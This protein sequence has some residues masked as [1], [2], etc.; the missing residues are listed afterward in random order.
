M[1]TKSSSPNKLTT[2]LYFLAFIGLGA[3]TS[4]LGPS[5]PSLAAH[6]QTNLAEIGFLFMARSLGYMIGS[7]RGGHAFDKLP[8]HNLLAGLLLL[9]SASLAL[10]PVISQLWVL[11][12]VL[13]FLGIGEGALD[14]GTNLLLSWVHRENATPFLNALHFFFGA[15]SFLGPIIVAQALRLE[16]DIQWAYWILAIYP[17]FLLIGMLRQPSPASPQTI[18]QK[19]NG[20]VPAFQTFLIV[21]FFAL[22]VGTEAGYG[23]WIYS[24]ALVM[25]LDT[26]TSAAF[27]TSIF[28]GSITIGRLVSIPLS[29]RLSPQNVLSVDL[30]GSLVA[31]ILL[32]TFPQSRLVL[33]LGTVVLG[34]SLASIFPTMLA[35]SGK[36]MPLTGKVTRWFFVGASI[37]GMSLPWLIGVLFEAI[38]PRI[39]LL[40]L[41]IDLMLAIMVYIWIITNWRRSHK[42]EDS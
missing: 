3:F 32:Y 26:E 11:T 13:L 21:A 23:G 41:I 30:M 14:M 1:A 17:L 38:S 12:L 28:W 40:A 8:G 37:G 25:N 6:T 35:F 36:Q 39:M 19:I 31:V 24:Y 4:I 33:W 15:G 9:I 7:L 34:L 42:L 22:Y 18:L 2:S 5:L 16:G 20:Q 29:A 27:L 10:A